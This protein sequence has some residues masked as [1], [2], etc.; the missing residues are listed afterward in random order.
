MRRQVTPVSCEGSIIDIPSLTV[1]LDYHVSCCWL[2]VASSFY[3]T[4][5]LR[6]NSSISVVTRRRA[7]LERVIS[8]VSLGVLRGFDLKTIRPF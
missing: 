8:I 6:A 7:V 1:A 4:R 3:C 2:F 5:Q